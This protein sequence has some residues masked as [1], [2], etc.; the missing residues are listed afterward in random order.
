MWMASILRPH[1][2]KFNTAIKLL[3][4][5]PG[6]TC[7]VA[8]VMSWKFMLDPN[9][10]LMATI[11]RAA[12]VTGFSLFNNAKIGDSHSVPADCLQQHGQ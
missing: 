1:G 10:G 8:L 11:L 12:G 6:V 5:L 7:S 9:I 2:P 4:Y 3:T